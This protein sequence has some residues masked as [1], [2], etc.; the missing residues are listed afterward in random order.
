MSARPT[1]YPRPGRLRRLISPLVAPPVFDF[2]SSRLHPLWRWERPL[3][4]IVERHAESAD[5]VTLVL[6][7]NRHWHGFLPGQHV[8]LGVEVDGARVTRS[9][10]LT[11]VPRADRRIAITVKRIEGGRVSAHLFERALI[12]E[13]LDIGPA[14]GEMVLPDTLSTPWL[15]LAAG[16]GITPLMAMIR[17]MAAQNMPVPVTLLYWARTREE[18][19][20]GRELEALANVH[21][22]FRVHVVLTRETVLVEGENAGRIDAAL[23][24][25]LVPDL[26]RRHVYACGPGGF[27]ATAQALL[28][29]RVAR[30]QAEAFTLPPRSFEDTGTVQVRLAASGRVLE[31]PR[32]MPLLQALEAEGLKPAHGCRMGICNT[33][34]CGKNAGATR[35]LPSGAID[36]EPATALKLCINSAASDLVLDI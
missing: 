2:W 19:C 34:V 9:Y 4:R 31:L 35:H 17:A 11:G 7:P 27:T 14:Y 3:A 32:G 33:C 29:G 10:S 36:A 23:L 26:A 13:V 5:A 28:D 8:N 24:D 21:A 15:F 22:N 20:F 12:G 30:F 25:R 6:Q 16:S 1:S 18:L